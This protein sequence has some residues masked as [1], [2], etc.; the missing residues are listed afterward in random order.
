MIIKNS[1]K[2]IHNMS[3]LSFTLY[4]ITLFTFVEHPVLYRLSQICFILFTVFACIEILYNNKFFT[5]IY[6]IYFSIIPFVF[7]ISYIWAVDSN[8]VISKS[9]TI[10]QISVLCILAY[11][12]IMY[13]SKEERIVDI[14]LIAGVCMCIY[15][16]VFYGPKEIIN[17]MITGYRL[18]SEISQENIF[19][20]NAAITVLACFYKCLYNNKK[21]FILIPL[22][23]IIAMSSGSKKALISIFIGIMIILF[24][25]YGLKHIFKLLLSTIFTVLVIWMILQNPIFESINGR[26]EEFMNIFNSSGKVDSSTQLRKDFI[27][28]GVD[29][30]LEKPF[31]GYGTSNYAEI[32]IVRPGYYSHNNFI[33]ILVNN[34]VI[35]FIIYYSAYIY[36]LYNLLLII[37]KDKIAPFLFTIIFIT[38]VMQVAIVVFY[39]KLQY[40]YLMFGFAYI[41]NKSLKNKV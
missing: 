12:V 2:F 6:L 8:I 4:M 29:K 41:K 31:L 26:M 9:I 19:G 3:I 33:E 22:P 11:N 40:I 28:F 1:N 16:V 38:L 17:S 20:M 39:D 27:E 23:F 34:G 24:L 7:L 30:F 36:I 13:D 35:G 25:K 14:I 18:G 15:S 32:N 37:K 5:N 10:S 21:Y